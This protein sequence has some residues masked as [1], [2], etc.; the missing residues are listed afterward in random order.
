MLIL[1]LNNKIISNK[2]FCNKVRIYLNDKI[3]R[4]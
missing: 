2:I 3:T 1:L 4:E